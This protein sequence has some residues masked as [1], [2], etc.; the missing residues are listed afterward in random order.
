VTTRGALADPRRAAASWIASLVLSLAACQAPG[1]VA[2]AAQPARYRLSYRGTG[3]LEGHFRAPGERRPFQLALDVSVD[4]DVRRLTTTSWTDDPAHAEIEVVWLRGEVVARTIGEAA[5][6][7]HEVVVGDQAAWARQLA[8]VGGGGAERVVAHPTFGDVVE[9]TAPGDAVEL[10][11]IAAPAS[12]ELAHYEVDL[13]WSASLRRVPATAAPEALSLPALSAAA[14]VPAGPIELALVA[15]GVHLARVPASDTASLVIEFADSLAVAETSL[16][17]AQGEALVAAIRARFPDKPI[18]HV[19]FGHYHP[20]YTGGLRAFFA[21]GAT[22]HAPA[23]GAE[24]ARAI[25]ARRFSRAPDRLAR[26]GAPV[27]VEVFRERFVLDDGAGQRLEAID[28]GAAS[29]H[30]DEYVVFYL[31]RSGVLF[32]GDLGWG[33][34][35]DG[36]VR[37]GRRSAG[38]Q[39]AIRERELSVTTLIQG[40]PLM[41]DHQ[42]LTIA[43]WQAALAAPR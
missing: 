37:A 38:L 25:A 35:G 14:A 13:A 31:P 36:T 26:T 34:R 27:N 11:R 2:P 24:L 4:G 6:A 15:P 28:I 19:F 16:T 9:R 23:R 30:T 40:W 20:H 41:P 12:V 32:Q 10:D 22:L 39:N 1:P 18:R 21:A 3:E 5:A 29:E 42:V 8:R 33:V 43:A 7:R 17:V